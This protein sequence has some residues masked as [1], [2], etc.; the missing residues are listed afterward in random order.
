V[1]STL[2]AFL[3][4]ALLSVAAPALAQSSAPPAGNGG[5]TV[6]CGGTFGYIG[7]GSGSVSGHVVGPAGIGAPV[8][9]AAPTNTSALTDNITHAAKLPVLQL[10]SRPASEHTGPLA[11][12]MLALTFGG[13]AFVYRKLPRPA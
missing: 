3:L 13:L 7:G 2:F 8:T 1:R 6:C 11:W 4:A 10:H 9:H 12:V 5:L